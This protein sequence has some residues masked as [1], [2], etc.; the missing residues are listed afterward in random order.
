MDK[1][2][3]KKILFA[4]IL[5][6]DVKSGDIAENIARFEAGLADIASSKTDISPGIIVLPELW[7]T[8]FAYDRLPELSGEIPSVL[9]IVRNLAAKYRVYIAG[10]LPEYSAG[11]YYNTLYIT[12]TNGTVGRY[13]KQRLFHPMGEDGFFSPASS[14]PQPILTE[15]GQVAALVCY[16]LRFP[17]ILRDQAGLGADIAVIAAQW[18]AARIGH[19][20]TLLQARAIENQMFV[21]GANRCGTT[22]D[23]SFG[24][25]S[26]IVAPDGAILLETEEF[27][28]F[29]GVTIDLEMIT[30]ARALF[31]TTPGR[32]GQ[33]SQ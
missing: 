23:M 2:G 7:A 26:M 14:A 13:R 4:G 31:R 6:L 30:E 15:I 27:E 22:G 8:G 10:S 3:L 17:E 28:V 19:W 32:P 25:H 33:S 9:T 29:Q 11:S 24:G 5:Q 20:R 16:D 12:G 21:I 18:P 1:T